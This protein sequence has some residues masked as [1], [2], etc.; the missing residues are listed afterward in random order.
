[1]KPTESLDETVSALAAS[2][3][4]SGAPRK[5]LEDLVIDSDVTAMDE[6][7]IFI[8]EGEYEL[9][10]YVT[11]SGRYRIGVTDKA[12]G[13]KREVRILGAGEL[14][15]E[16]SVLTG[17][18]RFAEVACVEAGR[19]LK[20]HRDELLRF[21]DAAPGVKERID[22]DYR[23][24]TLFSALRRLDIFSLVDDGSV[25]KLSRK[26]A[27][28]VHPKGTVIFAEGDDP[29]AFY[30]I[31]DGFVKMSRRMKEGDADFFD[32]RFDK[33]FDPRTKERP[34]DFTLAYLGS[35][36]YFGERALFS[37]RRRTMT[38]TAVTRV[39]TVRID[40]EDFEA[41]MERHPQLEMKLREVAAKR[42]KAPP[43]ESDP[44]RQEMLSW[45][46]SHDILVGDRIL[47]LDLDRCVRCLNCIDACAKLHHGV[48]RLTHNGLRFKTILIPTSCRHCREP[49]CMIGCPTGAI[50][51]DIHGE[52][53]HTDACIGCGN[54]ARRCPFGN[55]S[56]V[57]LDKAVG[58]TTLRERVHSWVASLFAADG[59]ADEE[60]S[61]KRKAVK[62]DMCKGYEHMGC[63]HNCPTG[64]IMT[65]EPKVFF[66][67]SDGE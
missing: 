60:Q 50:Q 16:M 40:R 22:A 9:V 56:M 65:V 20:I 13:K 8:H 2:P 43:K 12:T 58:K 44:A 36:A 31:R 19:T 11:L 66:T 18:P 1:M 54:C 45:V 64:A 30:L 24:R 5:A 46:E 59:E 34:T 63:Q 62:C 29:D 57:E 21:L 51:R 37:V 25:E 42:Y 38:A 47:I 55:I 52:V 23:S 17:N 27:L 53:F 61:V 6:G 3:F 39:E 32:S 48:T 10:C 49:T 33:G 35:G 41:L 15:G 4:F 28:S 7:E 14:L 67:G 26:V